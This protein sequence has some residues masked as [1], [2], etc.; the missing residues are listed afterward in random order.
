[1]KSRKTCTLTRNKR[2][3]DCETIKWNPFFSAPFRITHFIL[4]N[5]CAFRFRF[6]DFS[7]EHFRIDENCSHS[8]TYTRAHNRYSK[9]RA[10]RSLNHFQFIDTQNENEWVEWRIER[11]SIVERMHFIGFLCVHFSLL[12]KCQR[13]NIERHMLANRPVVV[14]YLHRIISHE[15]ERDA[16]EKKCKNLRTNANKT[17]DCIANDCQFAFGMKNRFERKCYDLFFVSLKMRMTETSV[18]THKKTAYRRHCSQTG[19]GFDSISVAP[20]FVAVHTNCI[21]C[22]WTERNETTFALY[23]TIT[24]CHKRSI[25]CLTFVVFCFS[26][27]A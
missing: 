10:I 21:F 3:S 2:K 5:S 13:F 26:K 25:C 16:N 9:Q 8:S 20:S 12:S 23:K 14:F 7:Q 1:M 24:I 17:F 18:S 19:I 6:I 22:N 15:R 11:V 27:I 4:S